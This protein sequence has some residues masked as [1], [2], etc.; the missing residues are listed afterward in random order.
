MKILKI[1][2][3]FCENQRIIVVLF[4]DVHKE[5][6]FTINLEDGREAPSKASNIKSFKTSL[7]KEKWNNVFLSQ[8]AEMAAIEFNLNIFHEF[9]SIHDKGTT[10]IESAKTIFLY[11][12][13]AN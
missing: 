5:N 3:I 7:E 11:Y 4:Y 9:W 12:F 10:F 13:S 2:E 8:T 6:M 1:H